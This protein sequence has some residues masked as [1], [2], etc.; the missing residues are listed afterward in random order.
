MGKASQCGHH[1]YRRSGL[2]GSADNSPQFEV[3]V[4]DQKQTFQWESP[5]PAQKVPS[6]DRVPRGEVYEY[7]WNKSEPIEIRLEK[8]AAK[9]RIR[10][11]QGGAGLNLKEVLLRK[12]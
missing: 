10:L 4:Q 11:I 1:P 8:G 2:V 6:P 5:G 3:E 9:L 7:H 12:I